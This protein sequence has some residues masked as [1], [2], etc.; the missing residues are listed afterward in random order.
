MCKIF[1]KYAIEMFADIKFSF[2]TWNKWSFV[3]QVTA[4]G[5][6]MDARTDSHV[7]HS[8]VLISRKISCCDI[9]LGSSN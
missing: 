6:H 1:W 3:R 2:Y 5:P 7:F 8:A 4:L 9:E